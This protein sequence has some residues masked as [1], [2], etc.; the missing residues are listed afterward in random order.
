MRVGKWRLVGDERRQR[1]DSRE[2]DSG[3]RSELERGE[4]VVPR[5]RDRESHMSLTDDRI[6][7]I[8]ERHC[9]REFRNDCVHKRHVMKDLNQGI[10]QSMI[11]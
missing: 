10:N 1:L 4:L 3:R 2:M 9:D 6:C 8:R 5:I 11:S 7:R